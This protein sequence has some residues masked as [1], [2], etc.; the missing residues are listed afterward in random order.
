MSPSWRT[1]PPMS[2]TSNMRW[3]DA[4]LRAS[5]PGPRFGGLADGRERLEDGVVEALAVL[6]PLPELRRLALEVGGGQLLEVGLERG[7]VGG[8]LLEPPDTTAL[9]DAENLLEVAYL[10]GSR[11]AA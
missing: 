5:R 4:R 1:I 2:C 11:V 10:H 3:P 7:D 8:L 6:E 9:A